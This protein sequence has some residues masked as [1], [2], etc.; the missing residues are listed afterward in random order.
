MQPNR[1]RGFA[2]VLL[3]ISLASAPV[4]AHHGWAGQEEQQTEI[5]GKVH[6]PVDLS[7][8]HATMQI[9]TEKGQVWDITLAPASRTESAGLTSKTFAV[10]DAVSVR[11]NRSSDPKRFEMKTVRVS[12]GGRNYDVYPDRIKPDQTK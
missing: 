9:I 8:P 12:S 5:S 3:G 4:L 10:G 11:G 6:K 2:A 1:S 7:G